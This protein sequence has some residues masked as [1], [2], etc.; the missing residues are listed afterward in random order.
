MT[1]LTLYDSSVGTVGAIL[2]AM[3]VI[4]M[5]ETAIPLHAR[6]RWNRAHLG[7]NLALTFMTFATNVFFNTALVMALASLQSNGVGLLHMLRFHP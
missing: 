6:G 4:A 1:S 3:A 2:I 5:I 7:P